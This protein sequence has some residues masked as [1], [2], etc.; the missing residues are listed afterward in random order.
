MA[1]STADTGI[2]L[3][4][5][6]Q[7]VTVDLEQ[8]G[9]E[10]LQKMRHVSCSVG[11]LARI[12]TVGRA[13]FVDGVIGSGNAPTP[14]AAVTVPPPAPQDI[15]TGSWT[16]GPTNPGSWRN[17]DWR[18]DTALLYQGVFGSG[19]PQYGAVW[20]GD[21]PSSLPGDLTAAVASLCRVQ[22]G[23]GA[24]APTIALYAGAERPEGA[25][26]VLGTEPG[27]LLTL[28]VPLDWELPS[29]WLAM[30]QSGAAGGLGCYLPSVDPALAL[31][32]DGS[33][34]TLTCWWRED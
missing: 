25:P 32:T 14:E 8:G 1:R 30:L 11:D 34:M 23:G 3:D 21:G 12:S 6:G 29:D 24:I 4:V 13:R 7:S 33:G 9:T 10:V 27:P 2:I 5:S 18:T 31:T 20:Y 19:S 17:G 16:F 15:V 22:G 26:L 28:G